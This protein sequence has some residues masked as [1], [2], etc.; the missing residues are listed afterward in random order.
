ML[1][2]LLEVYNDIFILEEGESGET[3][4]IAVDTGDA[5]PQTQAAQ[6]AFAVRREVAHQLQERTALFS[7]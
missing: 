4:L 1:L 2:S 3:D 6:P 5:Q 7:C